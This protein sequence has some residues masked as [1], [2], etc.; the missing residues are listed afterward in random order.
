MEDGD[1][2]EEYA[3]MDNGND[4]NS[5]T[6]NDTETLYYNLSGYGLSSEHKRAYDEAWL[7]FAEFLSQLP[8]LMD[9]VLYQHRDQLYDIDP[10]ELA[11]ATS[12][13]LYSIRA[14]CALYEEQGRFSFNSEA[15]AHMV[16]SGYAPGLRQLSLEYVQP[17]NSSALLEAVRAPKAPWEGFFRASLG[18][19]AADLPQNSSSMVSERARL[20]TLIL[21]NHFHRPYH[22]EFWRGYTNFGALRRLDLNS[23]VPLPTL[24]ALASMAMG[25]EFYSLEKLGLT[26]PSGQ[27][28][29]PPPLP[30]TNQDN[31]APSADLLISLFLQ[32][33]PPLTALTLRDNVGEA[34]FHTV[35]RRHDQSLR[36]LHLFY[37]YAAR[38]RRRHRGGPCPRPRAAV[39][40]L[41]DVRL[42]VR[43]R[44]GAPEE[45]AVYRALGGLPRL[46]RATLVLDCRV[47]RSSSDP[48]PA[49]KFKRLRETFVN[50][51][52][53][54]TLAL[55][56][57][58]EM[59]TATDAQLQHLGLEVAIEDAVAD[60]GYFEL[61]EW[62]RWIGRSWVLCAKYGTRG[63]VTVRETGWD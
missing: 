42:R 18:Q 41:E 39:S 43:R 20:E 46:R 58:R 10:D 15:L 12:P 22:P 38:R 26:L 57:F 3:P 36:K 51:A 11:L 19:P 8:A 6:E 62:A 16:T 33:L 4:D 28:N 34:T 31:T 37:P 9:L 50:L 25:N 59:T 49:G 54:E 53:D 63:E 21:N 1:P 61:R 47:P 13:C 27:S 23:D 40:R 35:L 29:P 24:Q 30:P 56:I 55:A 17:G 60:E 44:Q 5:Y 7:P 48:K 45:V 32:A 2:F 14:E 52:V